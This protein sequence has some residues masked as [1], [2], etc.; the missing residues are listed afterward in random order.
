MCCYKFGWNTGSLI[1]EF[2]TKHEQNLGR[3]RFQKISRPSIQTIHQ[4]N[5]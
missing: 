4:E 3:S 2:L 5:I 1:F